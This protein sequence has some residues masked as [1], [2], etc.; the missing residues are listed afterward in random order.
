MDIYTMHNVHVH[1]DDYVYIQFAGTT[2]DFN[3]PT[4]GRKSKF[5]TPAGG[6]I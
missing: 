2:D 3:P 1:C 6:E 5:E 4:V